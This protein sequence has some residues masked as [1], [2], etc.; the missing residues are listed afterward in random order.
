MSELWKSLKVGDSVR[1]VTWPS[2]LYPDRCHRET[3]EFYNWLLSSGNA[4]TIEEVDENGMPWGTVV[5][6]K[7]GVDLYETVY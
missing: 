1:L 6:Q 7:K 2:E 5:R 3:I 4:L